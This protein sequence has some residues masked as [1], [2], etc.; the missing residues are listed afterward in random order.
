MP[1]PKNKEDLVKRGRWSYRDKKFVK[2]NFTKYTL[3]ELSK[4]MDRDPKIV[5]KYVDYYKRGKGIETTIYDIKNTPVWKQLEKQFTPDELDY[6]EH[7]WSRYVQQFKED[8]LPTEESQIIE[9]I[10]LTI[11]SNRTLI[12]QKKNIDNIKKIEK[13]LSKEQIKP[14]SDQDLDLVGNLQDQLLSHRAA[15][16]N[17]SKEV[18]ELADKKGKV[19]QQ[20]KG[21]REARVKYLEGSKE[22]MAHWMRQLLTDAK[23]RHALGLEME[24]YRIAMELER[25]FLSEYH[26]YLDKSIDRPIL[27]SET[28]EGNE[29]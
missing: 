22:S 9:Y 15:S 4:L 12:E 13:E 10:T 5:E 25:K 2:E 24:K 7:E 23:T 28:V 18:R 16:E 19:L 11:L 1:K 27:N 14:R 17:I 6:F 29:T 21:T 26:T 3:E 8:I 20:L